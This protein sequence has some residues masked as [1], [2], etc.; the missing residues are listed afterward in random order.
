[1]DS[2]EEDFAKLERA[3][4]DKAI[5]DRMRQIAENSED[6]PVRFMGRTPPAED[7]CR[8]EMA[9]AP[10]PVR[11][12]GPDRYDMDHVRSKLADALDMW[13]PW[14]TYLCAEEA[15]RM[16]ADLD[17][18]DPA[19]QRA[20]L[21]ANAFIMNGAHMV[22]E[23]DRAL[24]AALEVHRSPLPEVVEYLP[25]AVIVFVDAGRE[26]EARSAA[27]RLEKLARP[28][29]PI[30][31]V[32]TMLVLAKFSKPQIIE[33]ATMKLVALFPDVTQR[34]LTLEVDPWGWFFRD[35]AAYEDEADQNDHAAC[36]F[37]KPLKLAGAM[38]GV[39]RI[40]DLTN[41]PEAASPFIH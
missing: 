5:V 12:S 32:A 23:H 3:A 15:L 6:L 7:V 21:K 30:V 25:G 4:T 37:R 16:C 28:G 19:T 17:P 8:D 11:G 14:S 35:G 40:F 22:E 2:F 9:A 38:A 34:L 20:V 41:E 26:D 29:A 39:K 18:T 1:V 36:M 33:T 24:E 10:Y 13:R 31:A 27:A